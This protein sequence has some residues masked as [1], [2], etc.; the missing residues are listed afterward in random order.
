MICLQNNA[1]IEGIEYI[2]G[3]VWLAETGDRRPELRATWEDIGTDL[4]RANKIKFLAPIGISF[5]NCDGWI[6]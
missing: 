3:F 4:A 1:R 5:R 2:C 6:Q